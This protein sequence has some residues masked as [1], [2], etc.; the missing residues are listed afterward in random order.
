[1]SKISELYNQDY[2]AWLNA[3]INSIKQGDLSNCDFE[4]IV[5]D[6]ELMGANELNALESNLIVLITHLF[7]WKYQSLYR[8]NS[9]IR[10]IDENRRRIRRA[11][12]TS[13]SLKTKLKTMY[14]EEEDVHK[15]AA[16]YFALETGLNANILEPHPEFTLDQ[17]L[18]ENFLPNF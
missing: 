17:L 15:Y 16:K 5:G 14:Y 6:L 10:T 1:M 8:S 2:H 4:H 3:N 18:D 9:W 7:K 11:L 13:P 12:K